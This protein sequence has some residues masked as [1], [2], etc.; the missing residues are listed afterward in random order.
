MPSPAL[1]VTRIG[2]KPVHHL[3]ISI[4]RSVGEERPLFGRRG[5]KADQVEV[6]SSQQNLLRSFQARREAAGF[7]F[8]GDKV[9]NGIAS[10]SPVF[11]HG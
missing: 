1:A 4:R 10:P 2:Q 11:Y 5:R 3:L 7:V 9:V 8:G 6:D